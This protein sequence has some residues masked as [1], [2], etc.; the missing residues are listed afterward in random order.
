M[1]VQDLYDVLGNN[2]Q[3]AFGLSGSYD[4]R[5][6]PYFPTE[7]GVLNVNAEQVIGTHQFVRGGY[8][9]RRYFKL[10]NRNDGSG[11]T[12][13]G[14][15]SAASITEEGKTP[16]YERYYAGGYSTIR[17]F[18]YRGV[19]PRW[20]GYGVGGNFEFYNSA[21]ICFPISADDNFR[22]VFFVDSGTVETSISKW[23]SNY[24]V[25][26]GFGLRLTIPMMGP[27]PIAFDFAFPINTN[28][29]DITQMF[30]FNMGWTR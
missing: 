11:A 10:W 24:R 23:E 14:L 6:N 5:D 7:G 29:G 9:L 26:P 28:N 4:T 25:A 8:E 21:E 20:Y 15:R 17:G 13:L 19:T 3:Y 16:I 18:E 22:G 12:V 30:S 2:A 1:P 27:V